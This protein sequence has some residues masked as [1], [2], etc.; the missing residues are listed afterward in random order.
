MKDS[1][2]S[3][4]QLIAELQD[5]RRKLGGVPPGPHG[6]GPVPEA[7]APSGNP[8]C[9]IFDSNKPAIALSHSGASEE[10]GCGQARR[11]ERFAEISDLADCFPGLVWIAHDSECHHITGNRRVRELLGLSSNHDPAGLVTG[12]WGAGHIKALKDGVEIPVEE[13]PVHMAA[14]GKE[15]R[16]FE[17]EVLLKNGGPL[18]L[19]GN[20]SPLND[21]EGK[22]CG[23]VAVF[24]DITGRRRSEDYLRKFELLAANSRDIILFMRASDGRILE[25]NAAAVHAYGYGRSE[26]LGL[27]LQDLRAPS[28]KRSAVAQMIEAE[29][30][31][32]LFE[33]F[34][35]RR[36][37]STFPVE[38]SSRGGVIGGTRT[39]VSVVRDITERKQAEE[40]T[41]RSE[42]RFKLLSAT[43]GRLLAADQPQ[44]VVNELCRN[45]MDHLDCHAFFNYIVDRKT[46][47][48]HLNACAG[49]S[50]EQAREIEYLDYGV[51]VCGCAAQGACRI[52]AED[53]QHSSDVRTLL[54]KSFGIQAYACHPLMVQGRAIGTLSFGTKSRPGFPEQDLAVMK[55]V[56]DQVASAME[57]MRL[58]EELEESRDELERHVRDRTA[59]LAKTVADLEATNQELQDFAYIASHDLQEPL[60]KIQTFGSLLQRSIADKLDETEKDYLARMESSARRM[61]QFILDLLDYS[62]VRSMPSPFTLVDLGD[63]ARE[64]LQVFEFHLQRNGGLVEIAKLPQIEADA[65]QMRQLLQNLIGN[66]L[67]FQPPGAAPIVKIWSKSVNRTTCRICIEDNGIGFDE[68]YLDRIF[69]PFQRLH[70]RHEY[71]GTGMGLAICRKIVERH[72]GSI[73]AK[74]RPGKG[75][76]FIITLPVK[77]KAADDDEVLQGPG[78]L[79]C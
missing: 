7:A 19:F 53:I 28:T 10:P 26:L 79:S 63:I 45:V 64:V 3:K 17:F 54:V 16:D 60:R 61:R 72:G 56:A 13:L 2:K 46:G 40:I 59:E 8:S 27:S 31:G 41:R 25:A 47:R 74:S 11:H 69:S 48:L 29:S 43:A 71:E 36:D 15:V 35:Q 6:D 52:V 49:I 42:A 75:S 78:T 5:L 21:V 77:H 23:A 50:E 66:A 70:G 57:R 58:I 33:T 12:G 67:K 51:A 39:L 24:V 4:E 22:T 65:T 44:A 32:I 68:A 55:T 34:H 1:E 18:H 37:G 9:G 73:S 20:A 14:K 30:K 62:R 38:V 76:T